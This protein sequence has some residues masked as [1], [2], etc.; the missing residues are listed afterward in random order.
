MHLVLLDFFFFFNDCFLLFIL[1][2]VSAN[3]KTATESDLLN[4]TAGVLKYDPDKIDA[5]VVERW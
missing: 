1:A 4:K 2:S 5:G 3:H